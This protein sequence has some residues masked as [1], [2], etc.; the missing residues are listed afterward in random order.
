MTTRDPELQGDYAD[1]GSVQ[2]QEAAYLEEDE[3]NLCPECGSYDIEF[4]MEE[5]EGK[6]LY[7][8]KVCKDCGYHFEE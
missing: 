1:Y 7:E 8:C 6:T 5:G 2:E 3:E 4:A